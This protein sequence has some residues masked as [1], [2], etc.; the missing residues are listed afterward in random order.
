MEEFVQKSRI[1][2]RQ[3][4]YIEVQVIPG[5]ILGGNIAFWLLVVD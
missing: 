3:S 1:A 2:E 5:S 4:V